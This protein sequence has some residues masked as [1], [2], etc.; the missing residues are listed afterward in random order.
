MAETAGARYEKFDDLIKR[1]RNLIRRLCWGRASGSEALCEELVQDCYISLWS[2][3]PSIREGANMFQEMAW[4]VWQCRSVFSHRN[5]AR[6]IDCVSIES[7]MAEGI[8]APVEGMLQEEIEELSGSLTA[9][10]RGLLE[11][12]MMGYGMTEIA[13]KVGMKVESVRKRRQ[14]IIEKM[15]VERIKSV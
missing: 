2:H 14:R 11:M 15:R 6:R 9:S 7:D 10:E 8:A 3:L 1:Y 5:K 4:V 12:M 13:D